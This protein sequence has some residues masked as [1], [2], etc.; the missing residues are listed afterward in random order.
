MVQKHTSID[1]LEQRLVLPDKSTVSSVLNGMGNGMMLTSLPL[2]A[3]ESSY[4]LLSKE[5]PPQLRMGSTVGII[6][7]LAG[8]VFGGF[9]GK[10]EAD[11]INNYRH[12]LREEITH[13]HKKVDAQRAPAKTWAD[14]VKSDGSEISR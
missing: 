14:E 1:A 7:I 4:K 2:L 5:A 12:A 3:I 10:K 9:Y 13:L 8:V 11:E 6:G